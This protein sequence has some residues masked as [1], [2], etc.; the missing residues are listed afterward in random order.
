MSLISHPWPPRPPDHTP[1]KTGAPH[2]PWLTREAI[3]YLERILKPSD[4]V[5]EYGM[6]GSTVW[7]SKRA[8]R[9][10]S[11]EHDLSWFDLVLKAVQQDPLLNVGL[12]HVPPDNDF[13]Q[14][15]QFGRKLGEG[16][17]GFDVVVV[18]GR[19]RVRC[20]R[21][22]SEFVLPGGLLVLDNAERPHYQEAQDFLSSWFVKR[23]SN[24]IWRTDLFR[25]A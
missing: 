17:G 15:V 13:E 2:E 24:G 18:D 23:T 12:H 8:L 1:D 5:L 19:R 20:I 22:I 4:K 11:I 9:V 21:A 25:K 14:Y 6:G 7:F 16:G 10:D 3:T